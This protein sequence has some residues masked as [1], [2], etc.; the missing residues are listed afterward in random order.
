MCFVKT[1]SVPNI[2]P[3][4][5]ERKQADASVTKNSQNQNKKS[6]FAQN[7]KTSAFGLTDEAV[8][9]KNTLLGE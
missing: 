7:V 3:E 8:T 5:V 6:G 1:P 2:Q 4:I 9:G